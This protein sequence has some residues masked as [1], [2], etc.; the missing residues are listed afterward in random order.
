M[1]F[2]KIGEQELIIVMIAP[3]IIYSV[4]S[5]WDDYDSVMLSVKSRLYNDYTF[6]RLYNNNSKLFG[7][8]N[9]EKYRDIIIDINSI[10]DSIIKYSKN[11]KLFCIHIKYDA[12]ALGLY[13]DE[14]I[15]RKLLF[16][17]IIDFFKYIHIIDK[18]RDFTTQV[19]SL[20]HII[21]RYELSVYSGACNSL[22]LLG[23]P[24]LDLIISKIKLLLNKYN[25]YIRPKY[26]MLYIVVYMNQILYS[27]KKSS[28]N[29]LGEYIDSLPLNSSFNKISNNVAIRNNRIKVLDFNIDI[30]TIFRDTH[31][32][33]KLL[34]NDINYSELDILN[35]ILQLGRLFNS[36]SSPKITISSI[37]ANPLFD[38]ARIL[39]HRISQI[40]HLIAK[41][42]LGYYSYLGIN[43]DIMGNININGYKNTDVNV[44]ICNGDLYMKYKNDWC[45]FRLYRE[46]EVIGG[47]G[48]SHDFYH[49]I[50][51]EYFNN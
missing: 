37:R 8:Y 38:R 29:N 15:M 4:L 3:D 51:H 6:M 23:N 41:I 21:S 47:N 33:L 26:L 1:I 5:F 20:C 2:G 31:I 17:C 40:E 43:M 19:V 50:I 34:I 46:L 18:D 35:I 13:L 7:K 44:V 28:K 11:N 16:N 42:R 27:Y 14:Y 9:M 39:R 45:I 48:M 36:A 12:N 25:I 10:I 24:H 30:D 49:S 22:L 32:E